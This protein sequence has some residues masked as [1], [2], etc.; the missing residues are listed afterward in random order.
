MLSLPCLEEPAC[1]SRTRQRRRNADAIA[2]RAYELYLQR[3]SVP[4]YELDDWLQAEAEL[5]SA[6]ATADESERPAPVQ[7]VVPPA[8]RARRGATAVEPTALKR[9]LALISCNPPRAL[10]L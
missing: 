5:S 1:P 8:R 9:Q 3:G 2:K 6:A 7:P 4:G 10:Q